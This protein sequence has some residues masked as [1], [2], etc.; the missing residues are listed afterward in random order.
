MARRE[1]YSHLPKRTS[2]TSETSKTL[3]VQIQG[4]RFRLGGFL[5]EERKV[6]ARQLALAVMLAFPLSHLR[7][8]ATSSPTKIFSPL[9]N[10]PPKPPKPSFE[11]GAFPRSRCFSKRGRSRRCPRASLAAQLLH[12]LDKPHH[13]VSDEEVMNRV[14]EGDANDEVMITF[15]QLVSGLRFRAR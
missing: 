9:Q 2:K 10:E 6:S 11:R 3:N 13:G 15:D 12:G 4:E 7:S 14:R 8:R 5:A 1:K